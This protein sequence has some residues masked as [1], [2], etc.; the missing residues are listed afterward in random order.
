MS[1]LPVPDP[2][3]ELL[4]PALDIQHDTDPA[5]DHGK[6]RRIPHLGHALL[7]F[8]LAFLIL[9]LVQGVALFSIHALTPAAAMQHPFVLALSLVVAYLITF[10]IAVPVFRTLWNRPF[11]DGISWTWRAV[12]LRWVQLL[13]LGCAL[14]VAAQWIE[15]LFKTPA[16]TDITKLLQTPLAAWLTVLFGSL[17]APVV[18]EIAFRGFLLPALATAYDWLALERTPAGLHRWQQTTGNTRGA[19]LFGALLSSLAFA[20][21]HGSQLHWATGPLVVLFIVSLTFSAIRIQ[22]RSVAAAVLVHIAYDAL[23]FVE[24]IV[25]THGFHHLDK[26]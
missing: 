5:D 22:T 17:L 13:L 10:A 7:L 2:N 16:E 1:D 24:V 3:A 8:S 19:L 21:L 11:L 12:Q 15:H 25:V 23:I 26:L 14:S 9:L 20:S 6:S 18:E 4:H